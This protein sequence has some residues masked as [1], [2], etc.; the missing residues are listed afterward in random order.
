MDAMALVR[1][2]KAHCGEEAQAQQTAKVVC[3][4]ALERERGR[5]VEREG[6]GES[7][8]AELAALFSFSFLFL[9]LSPLPSHP[10][11]RG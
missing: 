11:T 2:E 6:E 10:L 5:E 9:S 8:R 3:G 4:V 1:N 7:M